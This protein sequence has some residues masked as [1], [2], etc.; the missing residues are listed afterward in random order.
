[1]N[2]KVIPV[3]RDTEGLRLVLGQMLERDHDLLRLT[4]QLKGKSDAEQARRLASVAKVMLSPG[5]ER[6]A[7]HVML[8]ERMQK[9]GLPLGDLLLVEVNGLQVL[10][11][12]RLQH[13]YEHPTCFAC[14]MPQANRYQPMC[15]DCGVK[16]NR[17]GQK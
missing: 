2:F 1:M 13:R 15:L 14:G 5:Y 11:E 4:P 7:R 17:K 10:S 12:A 8:L 6:W 16:F 9:L 3:A